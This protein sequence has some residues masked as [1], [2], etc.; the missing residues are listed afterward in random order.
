MNCDS[1]E[2]PKNS[3][4]AA[5]TG[6]ILIRDCA[7]MVR[8]ILCGHSLTNDTLHTGQTDTILVLK[9]LA[10]CTDTTVTQVIDIVIITNTILQM[11]IVVYGSKD[12]FLGD[13]LWNQLRDIA[14]ASFDDILLRLVLVAGS[15]LTVDNTHPLSHQCSSDPHPGDNNE[16]QPSGWKEPLSHGFHAQPSHKEL[17]HSE[18]GLRSPL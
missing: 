5:V 4:T 7:V 6:L 17:Q 8:K 12:I 10:Y 2:L 11:N 9:Q 13:M 16:G 3:F 14:A 18:A 15:A 1:W